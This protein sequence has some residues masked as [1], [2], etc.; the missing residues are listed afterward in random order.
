MSNLKTQNVRPVLIWLTV[1]CLL[2]LAMVGVGGITRLTGSGLSMVDWKPIMGAIP[3]LNEADWQATFA[4]YQEFPQYQLHNQEMTLKEFKFIFFWEYI[5]RLLGRWIGVVFFV[6]FV[7]FL[8]RGRVRGA[9]AAKLGVAFVLG[10]LQGLL[11]W[12]MVKSGL[13]DNPYVSHYRL[14]AH[15]G[16]AFLLYGYLVWVIQDLLSPQR[17]AL[18]SGPR[19][20]KWK[21]AVI[22]FAIVL[23]LQIVYGAFTAGLRAGYAFNTFPT[24]MGRW[25]PAGMMALEPAAANFTTNATTVQFIHR[26]LG[27]LLGIG[28]LLLGVAGFSARLQPRQRLMIGIVAATT[29]LQFLLGVMTLVMVIPVTLAVLHQVT[30]CYLFGAAVSLVHAFVC[31]DEVY[32]AELAPRT[33]PEA[34]HHGTLGTGDIAESV[35]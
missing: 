3:P 31:P 22:A 17:A 11:G 25:I 29:L 6:P 28:A 8:A 1:V 30:A 26:G 9:M 20:S 10:G 15:L 34:A 24:M 27:W 19:G 32:Q 13:V 12:Y 7:W 4:Q 16:L 14:A 21:A 23:S 5:H 2:I 33:D 18:V 35:V